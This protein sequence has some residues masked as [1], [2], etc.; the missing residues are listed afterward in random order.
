ETVHYEAVGDQIILKEQ[1]VENEANKT[2]QGRVVDENKQ[3]L[4]GVNVVEKGTTNGTVTD[5][6]GRYSLSAG[7][8]AVLVFT[9]V[10]YKAQEIS[11]LGKTIIDAELVSDSKTLDELVVIGYGEQSKKLLTTAISKVNSEDIGTQVVANPADALSGMSSGV[12]VQSARGGFPGAAPA[13][14][15]RGVGTIGGSADV[16]YVVDGYPLQDADNFNQINPADIESMEVLK[17]AASAAIYGS[18]A[19]N[20]VVIVTTKSGKAGKAKFDVNFYQGFQEVAKRYSVMNGPEY[21][22]TVKKIYEVNSILQNKP[23][24][25]P[26]GLDNPNLP[27]TDWQKLVFRSANI[28]DFNISASGGTQK[29]KYMVSGGAFK[30]DGTMRGSSYDRYTAR[31]NLDAN[32][33]PR[34]HMGANLAPSY[35]DQNRLPVSGQFSDANETFIG[36]KLPNI[37]QATA[38]GLPIV[39]A[40]LPNGDYGLLSN[41]GLGLDERPLYNPLAVIENVKNRF[42]NYSFLGKTF[43]EYDI[44]D[45]LTAK[46]SIGISYTQIKQDGYIPP[47]VATNDAP[48][49][50]NSTPVAA[51][52]WAITRNSL[53]LDW[54]WENTL[55]YKF[56]LGADRQHH[57]TALAFGSLQRN[58]YQQVSTNGKTGSYFNATLDNPTASTDLQGGVDYGQN[59]FVS[60]GGRLNYDYKNRYIF[61][62]A[63][64]RDGASKFGPNNRYAAFPSVSAAWRIIE[65]NFMEGIK[66]KISDLK[67]R[68]SY[69]QTGNA[70]I[71]NFNWA[72]GIAPRSYVLGATRYLGG[73]LSGYPNYD[74]TWEK[75]EQYN[76]GIDIG[77]LNNKVNLAVDYYDRHTDGMLLNRELEGIYGYSRNAR[78]NVGALN[79]K[80]LEFAAETKF[81]IKQ[82]I[83]WTANYNFS[84]NKNQV[85]DLGGPVSLPSQGA[86]YGWNNS[87]KVVLGQ[88]LGDINGFIVEGMFKA[89]EDLAKYP[90][91]QG[92]GNALGDWRIKDTN[93]DGIITEADRT[94]LGNGIP[95]YYFGSTQR[96]AYRSFDLTVILQGVAKV[97]VLNGNLRQLY[98]IGDIS[99]NMLKEVKDNFYDPRNPQADVLLPAPYRVIGGGQAGIR[100][101]ATNIAVQDASFLRFKNITLGYN[102]SSSLLERLKIKRARFYVSGQN[103]L[104]FTKYKGLNP[105]ANIVSGESS[106]STN[107][108]GSGGSATVAGVDQGA[109]PAIRIYTCGVNFT[110]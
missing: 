31:F 57:F 40:R 80:G 14:R 30:Q 41:S 26:A 71:G 83:A 48:K 97:E 35:S 34:L 25:Y 81:Q 59:A 96:F 24:V 2:I 91:W 43:L 68:I 45:N 107:N 6:E 103:L 10:G 19:A 52:T 38:I 95:R 49:A 7:D 23:L 27:D 66:G 54:L 12:Q 60:I 74:L 50:N 20:G 11:T 62:A 37:F 75:N 108:L 92:N 28:R 22:A 101:Q 33:T 99:Y 17:D 3:P 98:G 53:A 73:G 104:T 102:F 13:I 70:N 8:E 39:P 93:G 88:P 79:N 110:F 1:T 78:T 42:Q 21:V 5:A 86:V 18:R 9:F 109:Y 87:H 51:N 67:L 47:N 69:G 82:K 84:V 36:R 89:P 76:F 105:E 15:I 16:L 65:E 72:N 64:R 77:L 56:D 85:T 44:I 61:A 55:T 63:L 29:M 106:G 58:R 4:P 90:Q 94:K 32:L 100:N 46:S